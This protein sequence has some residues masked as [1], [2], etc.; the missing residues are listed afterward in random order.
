MTDE[1]R[2][3]AAYYDAPEVGRYFSALWGGEDAHIGLYEGAAT[4]AQAANAI[5]DKMATMVPG[6]AKGGRV[7][8]LGAGY[9]GAMR[10]LVQRFPIEAVCLNLSAVQNRENVARTV[11][12]GLADRLHVVGGSFEAVPLR[13]EAVDVVWSEDALLHAHDYDAVAR[14]MM[15]VLKPGGHV[16]LTDILAEE[17]AD[18][19]A[20]APIGLRLNVPRFRT[21]SEIEAALTAAGLEMGPFVPLGEHL[22][23]HFRRVAAALEAMRDRLVAD[24]T[25]QEAIDR[26]AAGANDWIAAASDGHLAW[27]IV[28]AHKPGH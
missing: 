4:I 11:E 20:L 28:R 19:G 2:A 17:G 8:D 23:I 3:T 12:A 22:E 10:R 27:G 9:G 6:L 1:T 13:N 7:L 15:R 5:I 18:A 16:M 21:V 14:E 24:G 26:I 25:P